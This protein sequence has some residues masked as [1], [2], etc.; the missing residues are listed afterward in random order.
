MGFRR[1]VI[2]YCRASLWL[3]V[4]LALTAAHSWSAE[5]L[6]DSP[7][8]RFP[9]SIDDSVSLSVPEAEREVPVAAL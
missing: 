2:S 1:Y 4:V 3:W 8:E 6:Y 9:V 7:G 5:A